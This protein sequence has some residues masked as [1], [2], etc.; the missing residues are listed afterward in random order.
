MKR[1]GI[2]ISWIIAALLCMPAT[3]FAQAPYPNHPITVILPFTAGGGGDTILRLITAVLGTRLKTP[4]VVESRVGAGGQ[5]GVMHVVNAAP[6]GYTLLFMSS[7]IT[8]DPALRLKPVYDPLKDLRP[9]TLAYV[10]DQGIFINPKLPFASIRDLIAYAR[11]NPGKLNYSHPG[12]GSTAQLNM[13]LFKQKAN[14]DIVGIAFKGSPEALTSTMAGDTQ[15]T[16]T[17]PATNRQLWETGRIKLLA[18]AAPER[19]SV[20]PD[21]PTVAESGLPGYAASFW[22]GF[23]T[24]GGVTDAVFNRLESEI[25]SIIATP[26]MQQKIAS[27]GY[28]PSGIKSAAFRTLLSTEIRQWQ[29]VVQKAGIP[30]Q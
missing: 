17:Q 3:A 13:E 9:M 29:D 23:F 1:I 11:A 18:L 30:R 7:G 24:P 8:T 6:D 5:I 28:V 2:G 16:L 25:T 15:V 14:I 20:M 10:G 26:E 12:V 19:S 4:V 21:I 27:Y 22:Y